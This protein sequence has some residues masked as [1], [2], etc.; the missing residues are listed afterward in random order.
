[1][2]LDDLR[3]AAFN[4]CGLTTDQVIL[5]GVSGG[6]DSLALLIG[7]K[8]LGFMLKI[9]HLDHG[10]REDSKEDAD[11][12]EEFARTHLIPFI[13]ESID[14]GQVAEVE[15]QSIEEAAR[16]VRYQF[17]FEEARA[18]QAQAVAVGHHADDQVETVLM[19]FLRGSALPGLTGM[20]FRDTIPLWDD[21]I[22]LV[23]PLLSI[24]RKEIDAFLDGAGVSPRI[25]C[26]NRDVTYFRNKLR[27]TLI[28]QLEKYNPQIKQVLW[29][30]SDV[31]KE[32]D[33]LI[34]DLTQ[35][36]WQDCFL[37][38][39]EAR[40]ILYLSK[41]NDKPKAVQ[42]RLLRQA[43]SKLR[44]DLRDVGYEAVERA[45]DFA[46]DPS[47][48]GEM[49]MVARLNIAKLA[50]YL[51]IKTWE[52]DL[53]DWQLPLLPKPEIAM[54]LK[55]DQPAPLRHGW[56]LEAAFVKKMSDWRL[57]E[58]KESDPNEAWLDFD[59]LQM[60]LL[61]RSRRAGD[62][63]QPL[64]MG[65]HSQKLKDFFINEKIPEHLRDIWPL[66]CSGDEIAWVVGVRPS[67]IYKI[68]QKTKQIL[69]LR[70]VR[71]IA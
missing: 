13:I 26:T 7:L 47:Q 39:N 40:V 36:A 27:H 46:N 59:L 33:G 22:P 51:I 16:N 69:H 32:E 5:V 3:D 21:R 2:F 70:L 38:Q 58:T 18:A 65:N 61:I 71:K 52:S 11:F 67:E 62:R 42:R 30:M 64:G 68:T 60:P 20:S 41:F 25:D 53:P 48:S 17:L 45:L 37:R 63:W 8:R 34:N 55:I 1:M 57:I 50:D 56:Q 28:P 15:N 24:W 49:D 19:H 6:A 4:K 10:L 35:E 29:R 9:A 66:V 44:P 31:L 14:V 43:V 23:R 12:V 54:A